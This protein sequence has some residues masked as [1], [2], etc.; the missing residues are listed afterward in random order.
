VIGTLTRLYGVTVDRHTKISKFPLL[1]S[2]RKGLINK[3]IY[4]QDIFLY[5]VALVHIGTRFQ[6]LPRDVSRLH[7]L[8][9]GSGVKWLGREAE[10][11]PPAT[12]EVKDSS[13]RLFFSPDEFS[14]IYF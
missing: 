10:N 3:P 9:T 5:L 8:Q 11:S 14:F 6:T 4:R 13:E 1:N 2:L 12:A 7:S